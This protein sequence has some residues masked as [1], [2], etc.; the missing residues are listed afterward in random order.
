MSDVYVNDCLSDADTC[1]ENMSINDE[2]IV[3]LGQGGFSLKGFHFSGRD[4][5]EDL[6]NDQAS[7]SPL[8]LC[9]FKFA[10]FNTTPSACSPLFIFHVN[11]T[12]QT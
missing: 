3:A 7:V 10:H 1:E 5:L 8:E 6:S 11:A 9:S 4:P 2:L 12:Q